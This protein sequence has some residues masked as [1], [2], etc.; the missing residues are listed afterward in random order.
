MTRVGSRFSP[1]R[2]LAVGALLTAFATQTQAQVQAPFT[3]RYD[4]GVVIGSDWL[5]A[6]SLPLNRDAVQSGTIDASLRL[7]TWSI[8][9]GW[10][11]VARD[12]S[13]V[14]GGFVS[15]GYLLHW[16]RVLFIPAIALFGGQAQASRDSTGYDFIAVPCPTCTATQATTGHVPRY[17]YSSAASFGGGATFT[18]EVPIYRFIGARAV[19][20][21]WFF[22]GQP[23]ND[24]RARTLLGAGLSLRVGR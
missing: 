1:S 23:L 18:I 21:Q 24:D 9:A 2:L 5:Q 10:L 17:G 16:K 7:G 13:T 6:N 4:T 3:G 8:N 12:L 14:E 11:R 15:G 22:S 20:Q 19:V